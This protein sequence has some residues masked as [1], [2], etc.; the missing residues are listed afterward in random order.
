MYGHSKE[1]CP[2]FFCADSYS[3]HLTKYH[4]CMKECFGHAGLL[5][6]QSGSTGRLV[7]N[8]SI[9]LFGGLVVG[10]VSLANAMFLT[11]L[12]AVILCALLFFASYSKLD[13]WM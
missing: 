11:F 5:A 7:G 6:T 9:A 1:D 4:V 8:F 13:T 10:V 12:G 2:V 3:L